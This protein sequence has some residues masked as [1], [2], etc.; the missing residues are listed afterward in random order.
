MTALVVLAHPLR[1]SLCG[2]LADA[3]VEALTAA[4]HEVEFLDLYAEDFDPRLTAA[5][6]DTYYA[7]N[8]DASA[9]AAHAARLASA[10]ALVF[11]FPTWWFGPPAILKGWID[12][13]FAPGV[14]FDHGKDFGPIVPKLDRLRHVAVITTLGTPWWVDRFAML[15]PVRRMFKIA[16]IG[17]CAPNARLSYL[18]LYSAE[19]P[20]AR[21]VAAFERRVRAELSR[22]R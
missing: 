3:A 8:H 17:G 22:L 5:E 16:V 13:V 2:R 11:V 18:P 14:A 12:R 7:E 15:R 6:R 1:G 20:E 21:R 4:G 19:R 9:V 10:E